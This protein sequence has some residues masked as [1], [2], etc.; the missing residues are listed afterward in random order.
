MQVCDLQN[1][2]NEGI[3][4]GA[5]VLLK[6]SECFSRSVTWFKKPENIAA[7]VNAGV[8]T[9]SIGELW[10]KMTEDGYFDFEVAFDGVVHTATVFTMLQ[11]TD[12]AIRATGIGN[13]FRQVW[14]GYSLLTGN[15]HILAGKNAFDFVIHCGNLLVLRRLTSE[16]EPKAEV[17]NE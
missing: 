17:K 14:I 7:L 5:N 9:A 3:G 11:A 6:V 2:Q 8:L 13:I 12:W 16:E 4:K 10:Q 1:A 15:T